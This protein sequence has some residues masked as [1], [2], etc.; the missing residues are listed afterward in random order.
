VAANLTEVRIF[1]VSLRESI[2]APA[3]PRVFNRETNAALNNTGATS[4][5]PM[6]FFD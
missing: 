1:I 3:T 4:I 6:Y 2:G 5:S